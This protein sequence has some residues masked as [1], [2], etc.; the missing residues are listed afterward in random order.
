MWVAYSIVSF[1]TTAINKSARLDSQ[2][3]Y[4]WSLIPTVSAAYSESETDT[5]REYQNRLRI[6]I[7]ELESE[8]KIN[9]SVNVSNIQ[10]IKSLV[11]SGFDR[12]PDFG[13]AG[14]QN[15]TM[16]RAVDRDLELAIKSPSSTSQV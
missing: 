5:F 9:K 4:S 10:N 8:L 13:E 16:K 12:L 1:I 15:D 6:A 2:S 11:Q 14:T 3:K 7:Q